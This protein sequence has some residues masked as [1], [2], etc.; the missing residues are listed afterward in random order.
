MAFTLDSTLGDL[1]AD[2]RVL[3]V[4]EK[5][6]PGLST[7]PQVGIVKGFSLRNIV[8]HPLTAQL[9][10]TEEKANALLAE[11]NKLV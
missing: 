1:M 7:N 11:I 4:L 6:F 8:G 3:P 5:Q 10:L 9:G 2:P